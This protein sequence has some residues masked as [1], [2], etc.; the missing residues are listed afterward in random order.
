MDVLL[1]VCKSWQ[2]W[3]ILIWLSTNMLAKRPLTIKHK[4]QHNTSPK[5]SRHHPTLQWNCPLSPWI[6]Q[7]CPH[8]NSPCHIFLCLHAR[9]PPLGLALPPMLVPLF[10]G[11]ISVT[12]KN[13]GR[14]CIILT[15]GG[16]NLIAWHNNQIGRWSNIWCVRG[17]GASFCWSIS[18]P[19]P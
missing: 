12:W 7:T 6:G 9:Q 10:G 8:P 17:G 4:I 11:A 19:F 1:L 16:R 13:G 5:M 3:L 14:W 15:V 18:K 2:F